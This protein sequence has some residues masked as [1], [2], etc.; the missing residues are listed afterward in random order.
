MLDLSK[1]FYQIGIEEDTRDKRAFITPFGKYCFNRMPF[2]LRNAPAI[3]Q[4]TMEEV[5]RGCYR[6]SA[7]YI[8]DILVFSRSGVE[9]IEHLRE[10]LGALKRN[11]LTIKEDKCEFGKT[12]LEYLG[13]EIG[14]G[15]LAVPEHRATAMNEFRLPKTKKQLRSFLGSVSYYRRFIKDFAAYSSLLSPETSKRAPSVVRWNEGRLEAFNKLKGMLCDVCVLTIPSPE[16]CFSLNTDAS[17]LGIGATLNVYRDGVEKP[18]AFFPR[19]LQGAQKRYSAT[20]LEGLAV[21][22][23]VYFFDHFLY[24]RKFKVYTDHQALVSLLR[25][26]RLNKRLQGW[27]LKLMEF[28]FEVIYRPGSKNGDAD[29][30]SRQAWCTEEEDVVPE[31]SKQLRAAEI[32]VVGGDVGTNPTEEQARASK[33]K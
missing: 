20:E 12:H 13:H 28:D 29:G 1:G 8:D 33:S 11:G 7:P 18:V 9:Q 17:G 23:A 27:V 24:G 25:S 26:K 22:K 2:G 15:E 31:E 21:F 3:F 16:D 5:L 30:L 19:Q 10:V 4:R 6:F 32:S 14:G